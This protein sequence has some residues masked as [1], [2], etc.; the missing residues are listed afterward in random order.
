MSLMPE[1][2]FN[3]DMLEQAAAEYSSLLVHEVEDAEKEAEAL[4]AEIPDR[5]TKRLS[6]KYP[7]TA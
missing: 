6:R 7:G 4:N 5:V 1:N 3:H 2:D